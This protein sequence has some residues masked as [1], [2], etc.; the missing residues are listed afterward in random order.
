[1]NEVFSREKEGLQK[2]IE[3]LLTEKENSQQAFDKYRERARISLMKTANDQQIAE[4]VIQQ[5]KEQLKVYF[6]RKTISFC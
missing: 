1:M 3:S 5:L 4:N 6:T 2:Q